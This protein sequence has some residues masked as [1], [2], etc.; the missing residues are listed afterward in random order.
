[1]TFRNETIIDL[2]SYVRNIRHSLKIN[3]QIIFIIKTKEMIK[4]YHKITLLS[5]VFNNESEN[6]LGKKYYK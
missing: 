5:P 3:A 1:M 4:L 6:M 2:K